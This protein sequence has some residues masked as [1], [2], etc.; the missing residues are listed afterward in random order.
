MSADL[1]AN[2]ARRPELAVRPYWIFGARE[3][4]QYPPRHE[5]ITGSHRLYLQATWRGAEQHANLLPAPGSRHRQPGRG[6]RGAAA[7]EIGDVD[8]AEPPQ[9]SLRPGSTGTLPG[10]SR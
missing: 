10:R 8:Q 4:V 7:I 5:T 1:Y 6:P 9:G 3:P 2:K